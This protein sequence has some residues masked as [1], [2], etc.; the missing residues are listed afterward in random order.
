MAIHGPSARKDQAFWSLSPV[1]DGA[2][3]TANCPVYHIVEQPGGIER[4][5]EV[6]IPPESYYEALRA[7]MGNLHSKVPWWRRLWT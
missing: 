2:S 1:S 5:V 6:E 4:M 7:D 3:G